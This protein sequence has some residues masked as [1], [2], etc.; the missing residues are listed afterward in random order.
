MECSVC[1]VTK[2][3]TKDV[4]YPCF[5]CD[6]CRNIICLECSDL[7]TS[8]HRC[9]SLQKR[10]LKFN[11]KKCRS[12]ELVEVLQRTIVDKEKIIN[13]Q[14]IIINLLKE[15]IENLEKK[16]TVSYAEA[17]RQDG[18]AQ[19]AHTVRANLPRIIVKPKQQQSADRTQM[20]ISR[21][22][23]PAE[24]KVGVTNMKSTKSGSTV[25]KCPG[26]SELDV[27]KRALDSKL[28]DGYD[29][30]L[31]KLRQPRVKIVNITQDYTQEEIE[32]FVKEQN[33]ITGEVKIN[34]IRE[35]RNGTR[36]VICECTPNAFHQIL[37][38]KKLYLGWER[39]MAYED[40][41]VPK[42]QK[43]QGFYHK[44]KDCR[45]KV[46]CPVCSGE[47][48]EITC[49]KQSKFCRNCDLSNKRY[50]TNHATD[51][52]NNSPDCPTL[53]FHLDVLRSR[54]NYVE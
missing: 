8:E 40:L 6:S 48:E 1:K 44:K 31:T 51:H 11:C 53:K 24:L 36:T 18:H 43:C 4:K 50:K 20:D 5:Q 54:I 2:H 49:P 12:Y 30:E 39:Y 23:N 10:T 28:K 37:K 29:V 9:I 3:P 38:L 35:N 13:D 17:L 45:N 41:S 14:E 34:Y 46:V 33:K 25:I 16:N 27:L 22:I 21:Q 7:S 52:Q 15:K 42:C 32:K 47:H 19:V 26:R